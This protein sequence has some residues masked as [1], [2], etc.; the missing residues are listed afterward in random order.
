MKKAHLFLA[1]LAASHGVQAAKP[2]DPAQS[3]KRLNIL[4]AF[5]DDFGRYASV[6][7]ALEVDNEL[8]R[9][10]STPAFDRVAREGTLFMN[11][12]VPAPSST[13]CRSSI[14]SGRYFWNTGRGAI[15]Q[16]A[17]WDASIPSWPLI[18][19]QAGYH[20]GFTYKVWSPGT[21][22][23]APYGAQSNCYQKHGNKFCRFSQNA[24]RGD[25]GQ[26]VRQ[27]LY[28]EITGNFEDFLAARP[29]GEPFCYW[30]G[31]TN[32]HRPWVKGSGKKLWGL[33][34]D[35]LKG[36]LPACMPDVPEIRED[37]ADYLGECMA[38]DSG[39]A[40]IIKILEQRGELDNT[41][42]VVSGD[43][44]IPG[45]PHGKTNLY[46]L[47]TRVGLAVRYPAAVAAGRTVDDMVNL[48]DL[49]PTFLEYG[50]APIPDSVSGRSLKPLLESRNSG[51]IDKSRTY[52]ITGRERHVA[53]AR[54]DY[55]PYPHRAV[56]TAQYK[57]IRNFAPSRLPEGT[58]EAGFKDMDGGPTKSWLMENYHNAAYARYMDMAFGLRPYE[59]LYDLR[60]D[61]WEIVNLAYD[62]ASQKVRR[63]MGALMD[64]VLT[65][66]RDPRMA[67]GVC[68]FDTPEYA[69]PKEE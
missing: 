31:P 48:M 15:L 57:Y 11:A 39:L 46:N 29:A 24:S 12:H 60:K 27:E 47:G 69:A 28:D 2:A 52:V 26:A 30:W 6:Y 33:D 7:A 56:T 23:N 65:V 54:Q 64:S 42:I 34:P 8:C 49:A 55:L 36:R 20:I 5:G 13:P 35:R 9:M 40:V 63:E 21:P 4:F 32:T 16:G 53:D 37:F 41:I 59:E 58:F 68:R 3:Q 1:A 44:G 43:H 14:L 50:R 25:G 38:F 61:P 18:L 17:R 62:P 51:Q 66:W 19:E 67:P 45:F 22:A 10:V